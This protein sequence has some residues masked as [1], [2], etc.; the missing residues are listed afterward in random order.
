MSL[1]QH[2]FLLRRWAALSLAF[3]TL[4][5]LRAA[6]TV[7]SQPANHPLVVAYFPQW[8]VESQPQ[9]FV[10]NL[11][12]NGSAA[13]LDQVNYAQ[14]AVSD[15]HCS[16]ADP[17]ADL[18]YAFTAANSVDGTADQ[19]ASP[20]KGNF[21]QL[22]ELKQKYPRLKIL[23]SLEGSADFFAADAQPQKRQAF[24]ASCIDYFL[25][26]NIAPGISKPGLF[27]G[28]DVDWEYPKAESAANY[29]ALL[30]EFRRQMDGYRKGLRLTVAVGPNAHLYPGVDMAAVG[31]VVD[32]VG[33]MNYDY[34]GPWG[35]L[36]GMVAPL[37]VNPA[38]PHE[39]G[40]VDGTLRQ[41]E[42]LGIKPA[43]LLMGM[44][45]YGYGWTH[46]SPTHH[47][48]FQTGVPVDGDQPDHFL[49]GLMQHSTVYRDARTR[50]PWLYAKGD[51]WT[52]EDAVSLTYKVDYV[53]Q[54]G[55]GGVMIWEISGD[56][57]NG[58][59]LK[60]TYS[61][62]TRSKMPAADERTMVSKK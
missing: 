48:L 52:Y 10:K 2:G 33:V 20:F 15:S 12:A 56:L 30:A 50:A 51:F 7:A 42:A 14:A 34:A 54:K 45:F 17:K 11:A 36:T 28:I 25:K 22:E 38:D 21:H 1:R 32:E 27:D 18:N 55:L 53:R 39:R 47:G 23:I 57:N 58:S 8:G 41:Y 46:V 62:M 43:K 44:P 61:A 9:Y 31:R 29:L 49:A 16:M 19:A 40:S 13:L 6:P 3:A 26:G 60:A 37:Y 35:T 24:V 4:V 5:T 59:L